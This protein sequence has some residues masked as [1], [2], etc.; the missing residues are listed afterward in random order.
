MTSGSTVERG[1]MDAGDQKCMAASSFIAMLCVCKFL[2]DHIVNISPENTEIRDI[3]YVP[4]RDEGRVATPPAVGSCV[5][6]VPE[7]GWI[8]DDK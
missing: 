1:L 3:S 6:G 8:N 2:L 4:L 5:F 7:N